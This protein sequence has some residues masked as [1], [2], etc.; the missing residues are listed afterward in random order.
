MSWTAKLI[1]SI[2]IDIADFTIG[3]AAFPVP[4]LGE[5]IST[6]VCLLLWGPRGLLYLWELADMSE[7]VD[8][9]VPTA[10]LI[11]L[12]AYRREV[13]ERPDGGSETQDDADRP[14]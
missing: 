14:G 8:A 6:A 1:I 4:G 7:Q 3:R 12:T 10:T 9:F 2:L 11:A 13:A 5:A